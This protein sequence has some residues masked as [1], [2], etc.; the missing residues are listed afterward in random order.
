MVFRL[1]L[2]RYPPPRILQENWEEKARQ[3]ISCLAVAKELLHLSVSDGSEKA[4]EQKERGA[5]GEVKHKLVAIEV[6]N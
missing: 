3:V 4:G 6:A 1:V 5:Y 2:Q